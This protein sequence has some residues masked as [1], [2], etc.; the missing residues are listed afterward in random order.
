MRAGSL[1][2]GA[3]GVGGG[4]MVVVRMLETPQGFVCVLVGLPGEIA[5]GF[6]AVNCRRIERTRTRTTWVG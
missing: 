1:G 6:A 4:K 2:A 3:A 5:C